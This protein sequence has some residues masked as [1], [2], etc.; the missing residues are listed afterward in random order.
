MSLHIVHLELVEANDLVSNL[1]RH[2][3]PA[4]GHRFSVGVRDT[5]GTLVGAAIVGR[6]SARKINLRTHLEVTRLVTDG[7][8]HA[9]SAL[10]AAAARAGRELGYEHIQT[11]ILKE[12]PGTSLIAAGWEFEV[13]TIGGDWNRS[14]DGRGDRR[15]DQPMGPKQRWG[16]VLRVPFSFFVPQSVPRN[17]PSI[18]LGG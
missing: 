5:A 10:Y 4:R 2:H 12:E 15:T 16:K 8:K 3:K 17:L 14:T 11:Y 9:C 13:D 6:P 7:T 1:H 18:H